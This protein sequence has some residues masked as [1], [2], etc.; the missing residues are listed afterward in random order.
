MEAEPLEGVCDPAHTEFAGMGQKGPDESCAPLCRV[1][2]DQYDGQ[3]KLLNGGL[4][5]EAFERFYEL[6][7]REIASSWY[8]IYLR[9][10]GRKR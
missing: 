4:G 8:R 1:H 10:T 6:E 2:H 9:K 3:A 5:H 7:M